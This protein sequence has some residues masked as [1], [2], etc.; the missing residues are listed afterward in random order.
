MN[1]NSPIFP[2]LV[3]AIQEMLMADGI[4]FKELREAY[5][6]YLSDNTKSVENAWI[7]FSSELETHK[8]ILDYIQ[9]QTK[10]KKELVNI[11]QCFQYCLP[12]EN[13][14]LYGLILS[15]KSLNEHFQKYNREINKDFNL[16]YLI[17]ED[18]TIV[19]DYAEYI[20]KPN[21]WLLPCELQMVA[22]IFDINIKFSTFNPYKKTRTS[23][24]DFN[25]SGT[26]TVGVSFNGYG[27][28][29]RIH[30]HYIVQ[31]ST[32]PLMLS[33]Q[34]TAASHA[35]Q[36]L[37]QVAKEGTLSDTDSL[38]SAASDGLDADSKKSRKFR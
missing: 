7:K 32:A 22:I 27:H 18:K 17:S 23:L 11:K 35:V 13:G 3:S 36:H 16:S 26:S 24:V 9:T 25:A 21:Q 30:E 29:E 19:D 10:D 2:H 8:E 33:T 37:P 12:L 6:Q 15:I 28:F 5:Q 14:L 31:P 1:R 38:K 4:H 34:G 20:K